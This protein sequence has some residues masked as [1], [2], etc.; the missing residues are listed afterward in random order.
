MIVE[1]VINVGFHRERII[2]QLFQVLLFGC[3][4]HDDTL[5]TG[6]ER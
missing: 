4:A 5:S 1:V 6:V 2:E 3:V